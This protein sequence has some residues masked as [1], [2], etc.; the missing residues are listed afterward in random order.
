MKIAVALFFV[1]AAVF[2]FILSLSNEV[3]EERHA[4]PRKENRTTSDVDG[5]QSKVVPGRHVGD[6]AIQPP[7]TTTSPS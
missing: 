5:L 7:P 1:L 4:P 3:S 2:L 6:H